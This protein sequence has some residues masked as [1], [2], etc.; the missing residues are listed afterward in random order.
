MRAVSR[1]W[2]VLLAGALALAPA[3]AFAQQAP[4]SSS[5]APATD[6][7]GPKD[8]QGFSL[9]GTVTRAADQ[10]AA[11]APAPQRRQP[12]T[13]AQTAPT[14][15]QGAPTPVGT[16]R[17]ASRAPS[18]LAPQP[19][20]T[21]SAEASREPS[22]S[23]TQAEHS[24]QPLRESAPSSSVT[25]TLPT[26]GKG[27]AAAGAPTVPASTDFAPEPTTGTLA[28]EHKF[29]VLPWLLAA[30]ILG[31]GGAFLFWRNRSREVFAPAGG[32]QIDAFVAP[33]PAPPPRRA[34]T[35]PAPKPPGLSSLGIVS[36]RLRPWIDIGF[37]P[38]RCVLE[39]EQV[40]VEFELELFNSGSGPAR[41]VLVEATLFNAGPIQEQEIGAFFAN[42]V[43]EGERIVVIPPLKRIAIKTKVA[44]PSGRMQAYELAGR[45][46]FVPVIAFNALYGWSGGKGQTSVS[47]LLGRDTKGEKMAPFRLDLGPR[48]FRGLAGRLLPTGLR[49]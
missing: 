29:P 44:V 24:S 9:N 7:I 18:G 22:S 20:R 39:A 28:P 49:S 2:S 15:S 1:L 25:V 35:P 5:D 13:Q 36:T 27:S 8:L 47:Y 3:M 14:G 31:A 41:A 6:A 17:N 32:P 23:S 16:A 34:P 48:I 26:V 30:L 42:P 37:Q 19:T 33:E 12:Q 46:V 11:A 40:I 38:L 10:P 21:A 4:S 45:Q 43:G